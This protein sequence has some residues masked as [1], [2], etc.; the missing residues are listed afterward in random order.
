[1]NPTQIH[2]LQALHILKRDAEKMLKKAIE[3]ENW[4]AA[5][6]SQSYLNGIEVSMNV[7]KQAN[8]G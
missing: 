7:V 6:T 1:M 5:S 8:G 2:I 4:T 3:E